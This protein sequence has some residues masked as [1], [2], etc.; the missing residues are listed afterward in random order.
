M[1]EN[2]KISELPVADPINGSEVVPI[3]QGGTTK[4][5]ELSDLST[6]FPN[7]GL[8]SWDPSKQYQ[9]GD[10]ALFGYMLYEAVAT[11]TIGDNPD[12]NSDWAQQIV[13]ALAY[14]GPGSYAGIFQA[15]TGNYVGDALDKILNGTFVWTGNHNAGT[16]DLTNSGIISSN[17]GYKI[18]TNLIASDTG[19][20]KIGSLTDS[21]AVEIWTGGIMVMQAGFADFLTFNGSSGT[22]FKRAGTEIMRI[23]NNGTYNGILMSADFINNSDGGRTADLF[24][25]KLYSSSDVV[26]LDFAG[27][28]AAIEVSSTT[29]GVLFPRMTTTQKLAISS[30]VEGTEVYDLTL[31]QKSYYNGTVWVNY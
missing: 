25:R 4:K 21:K 18:G 17:D 28:N 11:P 27:T 23:S 12:G 1:A 24:A 6:L 3:V 26:V 2:K 5:I 16:F 31:H 20:V 29:Q 30:P 8:T 19:T 22:I 15:I 10:T 13:T 7:G 9:I 14:T